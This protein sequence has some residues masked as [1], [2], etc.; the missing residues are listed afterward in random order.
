ME[1]LPVRRSDAPYRLA[2]AVAIT[3]LLSACDQAAR[4]SAS[5]SGGATASAPGSAAVDPYA[6]RPTPSCDFGA[7][8][9]SIS[10]SRFLECVR[11]LEF[12]QD[13]HLADEQPLMYAA[14]RGRPPRIGPRARIEPERGSNA[15]SDGRQMYEGRVIARI[16]SDGAYEPLGIRRGIQYVWID[17]TRD[18]WRSLM[19]P[20]NDADSIVRLGV[21]VRRFAHLGPAPAASWGFDPGRGTFFNAT[22]HRWCCASC[23]PPGACPGFPGTS[24]RAEAMGGV[25]GVPAIGDTMARR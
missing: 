24:L 22:C 16:I 3:I 25:E 15:P 7:P 17:S 5:P 4:E 10:R 19:I 11:R 1:V 23:R 18:G 12:V 21:S 14:D 20:A 9:E 13:P 2:S 6:A 8:V